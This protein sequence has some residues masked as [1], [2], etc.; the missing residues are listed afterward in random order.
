[1]GEMEIQNEP[2]QKGFRNMHIQKKKIL[3]KKNISLV[4]PSTKMAVVRS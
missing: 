3:S 2:K 1:M 4:N